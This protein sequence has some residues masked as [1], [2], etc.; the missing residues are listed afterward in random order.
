MKQNLLKETN[1][2]KVISI[3]L[4]L[5]MSLILLAGCGGKGNSAK[6]AAQNGTGNSA[7]A[8]AAQ[9]TTEKTS[10][11]TPEKRLAAKGKTIRLGTL[12]FNNLTQDELSEKLNAHY[13]K[14]GKKYDFAYTYFDTLSSALLALKAG[15]IDRID[16]NQST[17]KYIASNNSD[18]SIRSL[19]WE[20][21]DFQM[22]VL[23]KKAS[24]LTVI[25]TAIADMKADGT[26]AK[27]TKDNIDSV[28][29]G[30][31]PKKVEMPVIN[32]GDTIRVA[33][34]GDLPPMD[35]TTTAGEPAGFNMAFLAELGKR[36]HKN[37]KL[38][39]VDSGARLT[40]LST[41][42]AD[43]LFWARTTGDA[44][45]QA[46]VPEGLDLSDTYFTD[47]FY[48]VYSKTEK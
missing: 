4:V 30:E 12:T 19:H 38:V 29:N 42:N 45:Y 15:K 2:K 7:T 37:I 6:S 1:M 16:M 22:A 5:E 13:K 11:L 10:F 47:A 31:E 46:D 26:L 3:I 48:G 28:L 8:T 36:I 32:G 23:E 17:A 43:A 21:F 35:Y 20:A 41:G 27:L 44:K 24:L 25:N 39:A 14:A 34:T 18:V 9:G 40:A 33:V